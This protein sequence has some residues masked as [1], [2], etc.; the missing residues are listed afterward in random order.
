[1]SFADATKSVFTQYVGFNGRAR[2]SEYWYFVLLNVIVSLVLSIL[3]QFAGFFSVLST[4]WSLAVLLP[5][6][7]VCVRRLHDIGKSW[8]WILLALIPVVGS[9]ILIVFFCKD[10]QPGANQ[11]GAN[12]KEA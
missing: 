10:S 4:I 6:L 9:I 12:P 1:M 8:A 11:F 3:G 7:A 2:R 5:S